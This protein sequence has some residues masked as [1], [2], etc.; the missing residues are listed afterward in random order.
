M[1]YFIVHVYN[2]E[3][4]MPELKIFLIFQYTLYRSV[5]SLTMLTHNLAISSL[6]FLSELQQVAFGLHICSVTWSN[7]VCF[8]EPNASQYFYGV[9]SA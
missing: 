8:I 1:A 6:V 4:C 3:F 7:I 5:K 2:S 9:L